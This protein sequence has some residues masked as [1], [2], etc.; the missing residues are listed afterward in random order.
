M[1]CQTKIVVGITWCHATLTVLANGCSDVISK[2]KAALSTPYLSIAAG[3]TTGLT[4]G[5]LSFRQF[6][7]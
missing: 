5:G 6:A 1:Q 4:F 3:G 7:L 2:S